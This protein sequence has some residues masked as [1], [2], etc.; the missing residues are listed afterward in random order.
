MIIIHNTLDESIRGR[1]AGVDYE[2][3]AKKDVP[4]EE[5]AARHIF[6]F[7]EPDKAAALLRLGW[8]M[9]GQTRDVAEQKLMKVIFKKAEVSITASKD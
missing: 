5:E 3:P 9:P 6:G 8:I 7:G 4:C 2:F 1:F